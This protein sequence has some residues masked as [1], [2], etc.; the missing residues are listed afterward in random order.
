MGGAKCKFN[1]N[2]ESGILALAQV[3]DGDQ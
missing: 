2:D 1:E 3:S